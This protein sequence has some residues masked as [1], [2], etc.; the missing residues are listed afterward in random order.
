M[1][2]MSQVLREHT[3]GMPT[4]GMSTRTVAREV[5]FNFFTISRIQRHFREFG[6]TSNRPQNLRPRVCRCVG[7]WFADINRVP[8][9]GMGLTASGL[10][11]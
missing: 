10:K 9:G 4:A 8:H 5:N 7:E 6:T 1:L 3:I 2:Q 11:P